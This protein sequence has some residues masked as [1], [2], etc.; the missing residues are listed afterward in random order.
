MDNTPLKDALLARAHTGTVPGWTAGVGTANPV[1]H[2]AA[3]TGLPA[4][5]PNPQAKTPPAWQRW[6]TSLHMQKAYANGWQPN[7]VLLRIL[8]GDKGKA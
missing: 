7:P 1:D 3:P 6:L 5:T 8:E 2:P 4:H